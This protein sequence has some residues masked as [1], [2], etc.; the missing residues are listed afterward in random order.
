MQRF[1]QVFTL[2]HLTIVLLNTYKILGGTSSIKFSKIPVCLFICLFICFFIRYRLFFSL[3][4]RS[5]QDGGPIPG[6][7]V[8]ILSSLLVLLG[9]TMICWQHLSRPALEF[10]LVC[11]SPVRIYIKNRISAV[12]R[13]YEYRWYRF[14]GHVPFRVITK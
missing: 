3:R 13:L 1:W 10:L 14:G 5:W 8:P 11:S 12:P 6:H 9:V 2:W 4:K 7:V